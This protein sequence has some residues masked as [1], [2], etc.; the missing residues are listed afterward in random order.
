MDITLK[1][2]TKN[3]IRRDLVTYKEYNR[4]ELIRIVVTKD[5]TT[6][7]DPTLEGRGIYVHKNSI[8]KGINKG[9][10]EKAIKR[11]GGSSK[12]I[13]EQLKTIK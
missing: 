10:I 8:D 5:G 2:T 12:E 1:K 9:S 13:L 6:K 11:F 3:N 7:I 4:E